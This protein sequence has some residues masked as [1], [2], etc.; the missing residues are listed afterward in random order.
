MS[1]PEPGPPEAPLARR[2]PIVNIPSAVALTIAGLVLI[3]LC[4]LA[5]PDRWDA[6]VLS[7]LAFVPGRLT[8]AFAPDRVVEPLLRLAAGS[9]RDLQQAQVN[10]FF[11]GDGATRPW[12]VLTYGLLHAEWVHLG[13]NALWLLAFGTPVARRLGSLRFVLFL[14]VTTFAGA[15]A[16]FVTHAA[17]LQPVIGASAAVSGC[18]GAALRF[19]FQPSQTFAAGLGLRAGPPP[20]QP[21]LSISG[22]ARD[23]RAATFFV[24]WF[25]TN[26]VFGLGSI[27]LG[28]AM[29]S[30]AWEAHIGGFLAG[31]VL[32]PMFDRRPPPSTVGQGDV[33]ASA[34]PSVPS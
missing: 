7:R 12:T 15:V 26:L 5:I 21:L 29:Q 20:Y 17:D 10:R 1:S 13:L 32:L 31:L 3:H 8:Y 16:H 22:V 2:E 11:L 14:A 30:V 4:R 27:G 24:V 6:D 18:M 19:A 23:R 25:L 28:G 9:A 34:E 33:T